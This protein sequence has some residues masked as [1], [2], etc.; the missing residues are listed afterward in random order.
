MDETLLITSQ[1]MLLHK[2]ANRFASSY[3]LDAEEVFQELQVIA[4]KAI[5][6]WQPERGRNLTSWIWKIAYQR[7]NERLESPKFREQ[8]GLKGPEPDACAPAKG[9]SLS[10]LLLDVSE[11]A[12]DVI[13]L[14]LNEGSRD[15]GYIQSLLYG[16][17]WSQ[18]QMRSVFQEIREAL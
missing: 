10:R 11:D 7:L 5:R 1:Q 18:E 8:Y 14:V 4:L 16:L 6:S 13:R 3:C 2:I 17:G 15:K 12:A 9:F